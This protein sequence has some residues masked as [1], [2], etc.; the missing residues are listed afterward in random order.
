VNKIASQSHLLHFRKKE[1]E[2]IATSIMEDTSRLSSAESDSKPDSLPIPQS[3]DSIAVLQKKM[4]ALAEV[5]R[6]GQ[7]VAIMT[8]YAAAANQERDAT[9]KAVAEMARFELEVWN[10]YSQ[11]KYPLPKIDWDVDRESAP[12]SIKSLRIARRRAEALNYLYKTEKADPGHSVWFTKH[13]L[14]HLT[15][16]K[17]AA[18]VIGAKR[19][20]MGGQCALSTVQ[21]ADLQSINQILSMSSQIL[22]EL[23]HKHMP[24]TI[25]SAQ[26]VLGSQRKVLQEILK[27][28]RRKREGTPDEP[29]KK[30]LLEQTTDE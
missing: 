2:L 9:N 13:Q 23:G 25:S 6:R 7:S 1:R 30:R 8:N 11:G 19:D 12:T 3:G 24:A 10:H 15:L 28:N 17:A 18:R 14:P 20:L 21:V 27:G 16:I 22:R 26:Q 4:L 29:C 5:V